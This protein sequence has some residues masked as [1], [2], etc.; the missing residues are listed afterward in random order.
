VYLDHIMNATSNA[1]P[2]RTYN[3]DLLQIDVEGKDYEVLQLN[4]WNQFYPVC[5]HYEWV[6]L[7]DN[8]QP[9]KDL[10]LK[11]GY[12]LKEMATDTLACQVAPHI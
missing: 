1:S 3:I 11:M 9:A 4:D 6:H 7:G 10:L 12:V 5:I 2:S 8:I